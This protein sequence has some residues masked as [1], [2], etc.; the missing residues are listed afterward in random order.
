MNRTAA[1]HKGK[2]GTLVL[3]VCVCFLAELLGHDTAN[4]LA[5]I[6]WRLLLSMAS[7][8]LGSSLLIEL[9]GA[10]SCASSDV[11][12]LI[13]S[14]FRCWK[15]FFP[16]PSWCYWF[17]RHFGVVSLDL[18]SEKE[19]SNVDTPAAGCTSHPALIRNNSLSSVFIYCL[20]QC[21]W[22]LRFVLSRTRHQ[23]MLKT[24]TIL[25]LFVPHSGNLL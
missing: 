1:S 19:V 8:L 9:M 17:V 22:E 24:F 7:P 16:L 11:T 6:L 14:C 2:T 4:V 10:I 18:D 20:L 25:P 23:Q 3:C 5:W 13:L 15:W 21:V 12:C